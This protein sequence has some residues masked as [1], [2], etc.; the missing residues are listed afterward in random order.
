MPQGLTLSEDEIGVVS[1]NTFDEFFLPELTDLSKRYGGIGIHCCADSMHQ[2][3]NFKKIPGLKVLNFVRPQDQ[4]LLTYK[5][6]E[7]LTAQVP[8]IIFDGHNPST[9]VDTFPKN[10]HIAIEVVAKDKE[11]A[12]V[13][14]DKLVNCGF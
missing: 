2:W 1:K 13:V 3:S 7:T 5:E 8:T 14:C 10:A 12:I 11:E 6:F 4:L 9:W